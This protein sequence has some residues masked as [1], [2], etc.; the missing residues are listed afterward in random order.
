MNGHEQKVLIVDDRWSIRNSVSH[1]LK[2]IGFKVDVT[3]CAEQ[4][5]FKLNESQFDVLITD[6][7][8]PNVNGF[9]L[10]TIVRE[11]H[12]AIKI[13]FMSDYDFED[14]QKKHRELRHYPQLSKPF[15]IGQLY[16]L[17]NVEATQMKV[18]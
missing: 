6:I 1:G 15:T 16:K 3:N 9:V 14:V 18:H 13:I 7:R 17:L 4:A 12:P 11:L 2:R 10:A 8:M 5:L